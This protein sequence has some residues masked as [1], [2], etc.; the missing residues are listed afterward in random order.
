[1]S[2][3]ELSSTPTSSDPE[4]GDT[5]ALTTDEKPRRA[6]DET[7]P[8][9]VRRR[10]SFL[11]YLLV[12]GVLTALFFAAVGVGTYTLNPL[13]Y[14]SGSITDLARATVVDGKNY[15]NYDL[16]IDLRA[17]RK[18]QIR[19]MPTAPDIVIVGGSRWQEARGDLFG[20]RKVFN[21][22]VSNDHVE[23]VMAITHLLDQAGK[24]PKTMILS[25]RFITFLP[26]SQRAGY[27]SN[28]WQLW[29]PEYKAM[30]AKLGIAP[31]SFL[32]SMPLQQWSGTFYYPGLVDRVQQ[33]S[34]ATD[35]PHATTDDQTQTLDILAADGSLHWSK[36]N[37]AKFTKPYVDKLVRTELQKSVST[38]P[39][40]DPEL[41][42]AMGKTIDYLRGKGVK[43]YIIQT[44]YHPDFY[45][46]IQGKPFGI[47][48]HH[49]ETIAADLAS[50][51]GAIAAGTY[52][53]APYHCTPAEFVDH[54]HP[55]PSCLGR[56][57][58]QVPG[59]LE[60]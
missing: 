21:A 46:A 37:K 42:S 16:N 41:V 53:P 57:V 19:L 45:N 22:F 2:V 23:D 43:V 58:A 7:A 40:V 25:E 52:D 8:P 51:H 11:R 14:D 39:A 13:V 50:Q 32:Q 35:S 5:S 60:G 28:D 17:V 48:M 27:A 56:V 29:A 33:L 54:I 12:F 1:M 3:D 55:I 4:S 31:H 30:A 59:L 24:L 44:P 36:K 6:A 34:K 38:S 20:G 47:H 10:S 9:P 15:A 18:E 26:V 49:L